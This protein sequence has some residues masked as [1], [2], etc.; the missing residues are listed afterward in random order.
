MEN[1]THSQVK[2]FCSVRTFYGLSLLHFNQLQLGNLGRKWQHRKQ[3]NFDRHE[4]VYPVITVNCLIFIPLTP[5]YRPEST[6][7]V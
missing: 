1:E 3:N 5:E 2:F 4:R 7:F 6:D